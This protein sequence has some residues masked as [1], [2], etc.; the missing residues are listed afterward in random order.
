MSTGD[1]HSHPQASE[2]MRK[3]VVNSRFILLRS[4]EKL[5]GDARRRFETLLHANRNICASHVL[6]DQ[7][8]MMYRAKDDNVATWRLS[9]WLRL[10]HECDIESLKRFGR[11]VRKSFNEV[12]NF[13]RY[14]ITSGQIDSA[15]AAISR[16]QAK[17]CGLFDVPYLFLKLRQ[18]FYQQI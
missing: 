17:A 3:V 12:I 7:F 9:E 10:L 1:T 11:G 8:S 15:N 14:C 16:I 2:S 18:S 6:K 13:F 5:D 4:K